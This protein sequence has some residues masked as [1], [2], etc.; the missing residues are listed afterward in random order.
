LVREDAHDLETTVENLA[1]FLNQSAAH[2]QEVLNRATG[3]P[4]F[5]EIVVKRD[6]DWGEVVAIETHQEDLPGVSMRITPRRHYPEGEVLAHV[7]GYVGEVTRDDLQIN[8]SYRS[9]DLIGKAGLERVFDEQLRGLDGGRQIE[10]DAL[11]RELRVLDQREAV[12]GSTLVLSIDLELQRVAAASLGENTGAIVALEPNSGDVL[13]MVSRPSFDPNQFTRGIPTAVWQK[14]VAHPQ[15]PLTHRALQGRYPPGSTFKFIV[16]AAALEEGLINP[17]NEIECR[18]SYRFGKRE[19][20]CWRD[21]GH[22][23]VNLREAIARSCDVFFYQVGQRL[24]VN[25]I[26]RYARRFG[27]G[28]PTG[29]ALGHE[30]GGLVP[31]TEWKQ[32]RFGEPW[33]PG[34]TLPVAIGQGYVSVTPLQMAQAVAVIGV[35][36]RYQPRIVLRSEGPDGAAVE[37]FAIRAAEELSIR[38]SALAE[39]RHGMVDVVNDNSGTGKNAALESIEVAG[40][41]GTSQ[42]V[43]FGSKRVKSKDLPLEHRDHAWFVAFAPAAAPEVALAVLVEHAEAGG[44]AVAAPLARQVLESYFRLKQERG[45]VRYAQN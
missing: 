41:T 34:E 45:P 33:Y 1:H 23:T 21:G 43:S 37:T 28:K 12:P 38:E 17:F 35:G 39:V 36:K 14:L 27:L 24:G 18:G 29:I 2:T 16:A 13:A 8:G 5:E 3:R 22:G 31:D 40:K 15:R 6:L 26:A 44:G 9:G 19:F 42:V 4:P 30:Q 7:L 20:R 10:V 32:Q 11:G 25:T